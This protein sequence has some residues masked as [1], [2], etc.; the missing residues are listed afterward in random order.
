MANRAREPIV[1]L[2][3]ALVITH[4]QYCVQFGVHFS[5]AD[6]MLLE[7]IQVR[8]TK[9]VKDLE[10]KTYEE[11][12]KEWGL[13]KLEKRKLR[14]D[15]ITIYNYLKESCNEAG[16]S[17]FPQVIRYRTQSYYGNFRL[18]MRKNFFT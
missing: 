1:T 5:K 14:G 2:Y 8:A 17:I 12:Q 3:V 6:I 9:L 13:F 7:C 4:L 18:G 16:V 11:Q 15:L 10:N